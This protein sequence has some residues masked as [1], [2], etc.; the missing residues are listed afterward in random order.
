MKASLD[1]FCGKWLGLVYVGGAV[2]SDSFQEYEQDYFCD[3]LHIVR[4]AIFAITQLSHGTSNSELKLLND[5]GIRM[6]RFNLYRVLNHTLGEIKEMSLCCF[7]HL[8]KLPQRGL[9]RLI[10]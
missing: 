1:Y 6:I 9:Y 5:I 4:E 10:D 8:I 2:A 3:A 7:N